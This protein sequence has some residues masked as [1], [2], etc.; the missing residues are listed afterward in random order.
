[1]WPLCAE[2]LDGVEDIYQSLCLHPLYGCAQSTECTCTT[3]ASTAVDNDGFVSGL[4]LGSGHL[5]NQVNH[6]SSTRRGTILWPCCEMEL[7]DNPGG[8]G[9]SLWEGGRNGVREVSGLWWQR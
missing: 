3:N 4:L 2:V 9:Q 1:V 6:P 7:F 8:A 5:I